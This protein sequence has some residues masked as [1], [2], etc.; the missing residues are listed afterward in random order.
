MASQRWRVYIVGLNRK[1]FYMP[2]VL[3]NVCVDDT[4]MRFDYCRC[5]LFPAV[6]ALNDLPRKNNDS[7]TRGPAFSHQGRRTPPLSPKLYWQ[8]RFSPLVDRIPRDDR[9][10]GMWPNSPQSHSIAYGSGQAY[11]VGGPN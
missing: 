9:E 1:L 3:F 4:L 8:A 10:L 2:Y 11:S 7:A 5:N 6:K